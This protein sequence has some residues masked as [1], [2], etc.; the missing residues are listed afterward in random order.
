MLF[1]LLAPASPSTGRL[2]PSYSSLLLYVHRDHVLM[3]CTRDGEPRTATA[4]FT[5][6]LSSDSERKNVQCCCTST[7][8][9]GTIRDGE[10][11][12][13]TSTVTLLLSTE[14]DGE[15]GKFNVVLPQRPQGLLGTGNP[16]RPPRLTFTQLLSSVLENFQVQCCFTS[17]ET[18]RTIRDG[19]PRTSTSTFTSF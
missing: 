17:T 5:Q 9:I 16:G 12:T 10:P 13:A 2:L 6:L 18:I 8:A 15:G 3:Y 14:G 1:P 4:T 7:E 19:E 11:R